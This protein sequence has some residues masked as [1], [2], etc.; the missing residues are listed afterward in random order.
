M[1]A[2]QLP[3][4]YNKNWDVLIED[5]RPSK[6][7]INAGRLLETLKFLLCFLISC[8]SRTPSF[9]ITTFTGNDHPTFVVA[10]VCYLVKQIWKT[11]TSNWKS[12]EWYFS[13]E[14]EWKSF[15]EEAQISLETD[16]GSI[17]DFTQYL[18]DKV[19]LESHICST[20]PINLNVFLN[21]VV[22]KS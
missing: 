5:W 15:T 9:I 8:S 4:E 20:E 21:N 3:D 12:H 10:L 17:K 14:K 11:V 7:H 13:I 2:L 19:E 6:C 1:K 16:V 18:Q 22:C